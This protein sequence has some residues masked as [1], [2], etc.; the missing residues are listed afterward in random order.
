MFEQ[1]DTHPEDRA[2]TRVIKEVMAD[3]EE[4]LPQTVSEDDPQQEQYQ[5]PPV[6]QPPVDDDLKEPGHRDPQRGKDQQCGAGKNTQAQIRFDE[7][8]ETMKSH[9]FSPHDFS[10]GFLVPFWTDFVCVVCVVAVMRPGRRNILL[11]R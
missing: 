1:L 9:N 4:Y 11:R 3:V 8:E 10:S 7:L 5:Q 6:I 2:R